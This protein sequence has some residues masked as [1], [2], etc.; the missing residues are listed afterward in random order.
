MHSKYQIFMGL[1]IEIDANVL[2]PRTETELLCRSV[3]PLFSHSGDHRIVDMCCGSGNLAL[4]LAHHFLNSH[5]WACDL[6]DGAIRATQKNC[7]SLK[8]Q[9]RISIEQGNMFH[10]LAGKGLEGNINLITCN[11]PYISSGRLDQDKAYLLDC[12]PREA[13]DGGPYGISVLQKLVKDAQSFLAP[14]GWL[15]FEFGEG[16]H[17]QAERLLIRAK[18]YDQIRLIENE[19]AIP[20]VALARKHSRDI[21]VNA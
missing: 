16:Q 19:N 9:D 12:E 2:A 6:T 4:A 1:D 8:L 5:V 18:N 13:F 20:R 7:L 3:L 17:R 10:A 14:G 11:P 21:N 15:A